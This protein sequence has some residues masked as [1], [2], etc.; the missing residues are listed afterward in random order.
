MSG[1]SERVRGRSALIPFDMTSGVLTALIVA[2]MTFMACVALAGASGAARLADSWTSGLTAAAT[3]RIEAGDS[4]RARRV[5]AV[6]EILR[7]TEGVIEVE[8]LSNDDVQALL[9]PWFGGVAELDGLPTP[10][11]VAVTLDP[12]R[13]PDPK[14]VQARLDGAGTGAI[15]DDHGRWRA[16]AA[17]GARAVRGV[18]LGALVL[19]MLA[20]AS[21]V[22]VAVRIGLSAHHETISALRLAGAEDRFVARLYQIRYFWIGLIGALCGVAFALLALLGFDAISRIGAALPMLE[23]PDYWPL[24][25]ILVVVF[26]AFITVIA[27]RITVLTSLRSQS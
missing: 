15:Y 20:L 24:A 21:V 22:V 12:E 14:I 25:L 3:V 9:E 26:A 19:A 23:A 18:S 2:A 17:D 5:S 16:R 4:D 27:A 6:L 13:E 11:I 7:E 10:D 1:A 8:T